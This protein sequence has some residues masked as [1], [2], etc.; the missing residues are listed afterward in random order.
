MRASTQ[1]WYP[2]TLGTLWD[3][4]HPEPGEPPVD[5]RNGPKARRYQHRRDHEMRLAH[6][7]RSAR[8]D[9]FYCGDYRNLGPGS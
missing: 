6:A 5:W 3:G 9:Q 2:R 7:E 1:K 8:G 4:G